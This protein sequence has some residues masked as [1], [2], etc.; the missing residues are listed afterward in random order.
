MELNHT[1]PA[2]YPPFAAR[3]AWSPPALARLWPAFG[4]VALLGTPV[5]AQGLRKAPVL[6]PVVEQSGNRQTISLESGNGRVIALPGPATNVFV[7]DPRV[8]EV[9]PASTNSLFVFGVGA[10]RTTIAA[11]DNEGRA[12]AQFEVTVRPSTFVAAEAEAM[13]AR[14][15][16]NGRIKVTPQARGMILTGSVASPAE[17]ARAVA[18]LKG[19]IPEGQSVENQLSVQ[20]SIQVN[21]RVRVVEMQRS[22]T[23]ALGIDWQAMGS[24]GRFALNFGSTTGLGGLASAAAGALKVGTKDANAL[25]DALAQ[26]NLVRVLAEPNLTVMSGQPG[27]FLAGGEFPV[28]VAQSP[29]T[30]GAGSTITVTF[31]K[32]GVSLDVVPTVLTDGRINLHIAPEVSQLTTTGA[33]TLSSGSAGGTALSIPGV[34]VRRAETSVELGSGQSFAIAGLLQDT[35]TQNTSGL[36]FLGDLPVLGP[37]FRSSSFQKQET[38][39]VIIVTP[40]IVRPVDD[41]ALLHTAEDRFKAPNDLERILLLRQVGASNAAVP[42]RIPGAAG[43]IVQ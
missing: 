27:S 19:Y 34:A 8:A 9:R 7:A 10:G 16:P 5:H 22:V 13:V 4:L 31:K 28:P 41:P 17:A 24:V 12:V 36:A 23:R 26:D 35:V 30:A 21:M 39:L 18:I 42:G 14:L 2:T 38:E 6:Q 3:S 43:F 25:I 29:A 20:A 15:V 32:Y 1:S 40:Y 37:L 11:M 33:V